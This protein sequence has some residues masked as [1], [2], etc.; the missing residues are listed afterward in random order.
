MDDIAGECIEE[1]KGR[2][3]QVER[4]GE[5]YETPLETVRNLR[6]SAG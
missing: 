1:T 6:Q 4:N 3:F 5:Q 2:E